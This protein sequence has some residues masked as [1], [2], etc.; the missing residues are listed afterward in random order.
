MSAAAFH[1]G[2]VGMEQAKDSLARMLENRRVPPG[3]LLYGSPG[4]GKRTLALAFA[5]ALLGRPLSTVWSEDGTEPGHPDLVVLERG[6]EHRQVGIAQIRQL[7]ETFGLTPVEA[8][9]RVA[10]VL[11]AERLTI[12]AGNALLKLLEE[13][14]PSAH[15]ILTA[16]DRDAVM[17][18]LVSRCRT[19]RAAPASD[20]EVLAFLISN[21]VDPERAAAL[22]LLCEGSPGLALGMAADGAFEK[23]VGQPLRLICGTA[24]PEGAADAV[25]ALMRQGAASKLEVGRQRLRVALDAL[26]R[27]LRLALRQVAGRQAAADRLHADLPELA[28]L[29]GSMTPRDVEKFATVVLESRADLDRNLAPELI[30]ANLVRALRHAAA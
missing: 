20:E 1:A 17:E 11:D 12:E 14:P 6:V 8:P 24:D 2:I 21:G 19:L 29:I 23:Q 10:I 15:I 27:F 13:P 28:A 25:M 16:R 26:L 9:G 22:A 18:T 5:A 30:M 4:R 7:K 3:L